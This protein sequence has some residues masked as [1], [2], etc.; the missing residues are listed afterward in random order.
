MNRFPDQKAIIF[1][2]CDPCGTAVKR[3]Y[4]LLCEEAHQHSYCL[5]CYVLV[6]CASHR[7][8]D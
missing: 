8:L 1:P 7:W 6:T 5:H 2:K 3:P 4:Y